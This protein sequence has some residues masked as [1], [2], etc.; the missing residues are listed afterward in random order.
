MLAPPKIKAAAEPALLR[1]AGMSFALM[2]VA[3]L[4]V[5]YFFNPT[6]YGFYPVC[7]FHRLTGLNCPGCG[8]TR[9][10]FALLH[11]QFQVALRDNAL[12]LGCLIFGVGRLLWVQGQ[13]WRG[14]TQVPF[15]R[16]WMLW[17]LLAVTV[18]F[19]IIRNLPGFEWLSPV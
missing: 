17:T 1:W 8:A 2:I 4:V 5:L 12:L 13:H 3:G 6:K 7:Q 16:I 19:G 10:L 11:G 14:Q 15:L 18:I 9:A